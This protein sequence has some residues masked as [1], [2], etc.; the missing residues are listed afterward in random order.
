MTGIT[1]YKTDEC[2]LEITPKRTIHDIKV[3]N[4]EFNRCVAM[5][6]ESSFHQYWGDIN[7]SVKDL[8]EDCKK[9]S[10]KTKDAV[11]NDS[12][13]DSKARDSFRNYPPNFRPCIS[14]DGRS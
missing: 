1:K 10:L 7:I 12:Q 11:I 4:T 3:F 8:L 2:I 5:V 9:N 6:T 14:H 13:Y